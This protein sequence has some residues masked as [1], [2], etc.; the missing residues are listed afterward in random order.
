MIFSGNVFPD[1]GRHR[2]KPDSGRKERAFR[3]VTSGRVKV[4]YWWLF[5]GGLSNENLK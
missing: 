1:L 3:V 5:R 4:R 2:R